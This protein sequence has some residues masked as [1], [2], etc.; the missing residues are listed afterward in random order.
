MV[1]CHY[2]IQR[3][4]AN[5]IHHV[6]EG[7]LWPWSVPSQKENLILMLRFGRL[8]YL[9]VGFFTCLLRSI[10][11]PMRGLLHA[12]FIHDDLGF[13]CAVTLQPCLHLPGR[14]H[15]LVC[16]QQSFCQSCMAGTRVYVCM[17]VYLTFR[18]E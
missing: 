9:T 14:Q 8:N 13:R 12:L 11:I 4:H 6:S 3:H 15:E 17:C 5:I 10:E 18:S 7:M 2:M 1:A 16:T